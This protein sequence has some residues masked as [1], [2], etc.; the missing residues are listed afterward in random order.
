MDHK[1]GSLGIAV[2]GSRVGGKLEVGEIKYR[3]KQAGFELDKSLLTTGWHILSG[4][5]FKEFFPWAGQ[6]NFPIYYFDDI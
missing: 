2:V 1:I 4:T 5:L 3:Y 6:V